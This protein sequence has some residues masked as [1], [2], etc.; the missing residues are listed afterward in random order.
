MFGIAFRPGGFRPFLGSRVSALTDRMIRA[1]DVPGL[2]P[3]PAE[4]IDVPAV[5]RWLRAARPL[6]DPTTLKAAGIVEMIAAETGIARVDAVAER[7]GMSVRNLQRLFAEHVG[8][9]PK[10]VI[11]RYRLREATERMAAGG[12]VDWAALAVELGYADQAHFCRD[13]TAMYGEP[14]TYYARRY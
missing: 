1:A 10:W 9:S 14:P 13:F 4:P 3:P 11:R 6:A 5:E 7:C 2:P 12:T 8:V